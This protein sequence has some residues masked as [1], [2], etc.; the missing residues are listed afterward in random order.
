MPLGD[1]LMVSA[2]HFQV[3]GA[4]EHACAH[5]HTC[6]HIHTHTH[7]H[8]HTQIHTHTYTC[9]HTYI[10]THAQTQ[11]QEGNQMWQTITEL[12]LGKGHLCIDCTIL[13][14]LL[15]AFYFVQNKHLRVEGLRVQEIIHTDTH[16]HGQKLPHTGVHQG[17]QSTMVPM[18]W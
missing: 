9:R 2:T 8:T 10:H 15:K 4:N 16:T 17:L 6:A 3:V 1:M 12:L 7:T 18:L 11:T 13:S 5:T 14:T